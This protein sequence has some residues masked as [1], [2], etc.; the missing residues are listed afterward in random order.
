MEIE[1]SGKD[2]DK[3]TTNALRTTITLIKTDST[4][5]TLRMTT[6]ATIRA[7]KDRGPIM[8]NNQIIMEAINQI[9]RGLT[10]VEAATYTDKTT[11]TEGSETK[12]EMNKQVEISFR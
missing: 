10:I 4:R 7:T 1:D 2:L 5:I 11:I 9:Q 12:T 8:I 6:M 3:I